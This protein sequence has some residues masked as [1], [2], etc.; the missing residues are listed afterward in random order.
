MPEIEQLVRTL[1]AMAL[2][3]KPDKDERQQPGTDR[4]WVVKLVL[5]LVIL[6]GVLWL[7]Y[8]LYLKAKALADARTQLEHQKIE[9][10]RMKIAAAVQTNTAVKD[11]ALKAAAELTASVAAKEMALQAAEERHAEAVKKV[12]ALRSWEELNKLAGIQS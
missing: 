12:E 7:R 8:S 5:G 4:T 1:A 3:V 9:A 11:Q 6:L 2:E 10:E